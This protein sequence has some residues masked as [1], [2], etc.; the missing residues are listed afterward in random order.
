MTRPLPA[1]PCLALLKAF[2]KDNPDPPA[3]MNAAAAALTAALSA[4]SLVDLND[5]QYAAL[6]DRVID[7]GIDAFKATR[8]FDLV[9]GGNLTLPVYEF[10]TFGNRGLAELDVWLVGNST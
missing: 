5:G 8:L 6:I 10:K 1:A 7:M 9:D 2:D 4:Q 3:A